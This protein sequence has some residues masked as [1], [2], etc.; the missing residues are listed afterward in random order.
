MPACHLVAM[1]PA[2]PTRVPSTRSQ[3]CPSHPVPIMHQTRKIRLVV[4]R[5]E[6]K[7]ARHDPPHALG[8]H[9][10]DRQYLPSSPKTQRCKSNN[11]RPSSASTTSL[12]IRPLSCS[13]NAFV[14]AV[15]LPEGQAQLQLAPS[16]A[17]RF[18]T[19]FPVPGAASFDV[20]I[21]QNG[22]VDV[23]F[24]AFSTGGAVTSHAEAGSKDWAP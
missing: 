9:T 15:P 18:C 1:A 7:N 3:S 19:G 17:H 6:V 11:N 13:L 22:R 16:P 24:A 23:I 5:G 12:T 4:R 21:T 8:P 10:V 14:T 20:A 2:V